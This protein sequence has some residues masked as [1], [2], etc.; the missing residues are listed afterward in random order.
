M[1]TMPRRVHENTKLLF[2][3]YTPPPL[4]KGDRTRCLYRDADVVVTSWSDG[5]ISWP[6]CRALGHRGGSGLP[7]EEELARAVRSE[8]AAALMYWWGVNGRTAWAWRKA[9]GVEGR[10]GTEGSRRLIQAAA[11]KGADQ[12]R[13]KP[14][15]PE[16]VEQRRRTARAL[17]LGQYLDPAH[18]RG[19]TR[20]ELRLLGKVSDAQVAALTGRSEN[21]VRQKRNKLGIPTFSDGGAGTAE[22]LGVD[23][24]RACQLHTARY[25][26]PSPGRGVER[27]CLSCSWM[28]SGIF[29]RGKTWQAARRSAAALGMP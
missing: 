23:L 10:D 20:A 9:L 17:I 11:E 6:R 8:S 15:S 18:G 5:R 29:A 22:A 28:A 4:R 24:A 1:S 7:V 16:Q 14:L 12:V 26:R 27:A 3:P 2:G 19:W 21:A 13:G 25:P